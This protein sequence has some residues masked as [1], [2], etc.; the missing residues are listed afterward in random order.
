LHIRVLA[1]GI[2]ARLIEAEAALQGHDPLTWLATLNHLRQTAWPTIQPA[3]A[4]PLDSLSDPGSDTARVSL[5]FRE[6]AFWLFLTG[7]RQGDLRRLV[8]QYGRAPNTVYPTGVYPGGPGHY[9][10]DV[11]VPI[12]A[13][14]RTY[15]SLF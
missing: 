13:E 8:S 15:N 14:E 4:G 7:H 3:V 2:E 6:R 10:S 5:T 12:P 9:G 1:D 11:T